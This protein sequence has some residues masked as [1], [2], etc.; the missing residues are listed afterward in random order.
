MSCRNGLLAVARDAVDLDVGGHDRARVRFLDRGVERREEGLADHALRVV[1]RADVHAGLGLAVHGEVLQRRDDVAGVD[2]PVR[3]GRALQPAHGGDAHARHQVRVLAVG[4]L[5]AAPARIAHDVDDGR[6]RVLRAARARLLRDGG[7]DLLDQRGIEAGRQ[8]D[9]L[10]VAGRAHA[11]HAVQPLFVVQQRDAEAR[12]LDDVLLQG[13]RQLRFLARVQVLLAVLVL[14]RARDLTQAVG[15]QRLRLVVREGGAQ[16]IVDQHAALREPVGG[17][18]RDLLFQRH[19]REQIGDALVRRQLR[20]EVLRLRE[21]G[22]AGGGG[23]GGTGR[24]TDGDQQGQG[25]RSFHAGERMP[26]RAP[27][28]NQP[29]PDDLRALTCPA[30]G[31]RRSDCSRGRR[32]SCRRHPGAQIR[33]PRPRCWSSSRS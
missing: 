26:N 32:S 31:S 3:L 9:R 19:A 16:L 12:V 17:E 27:A 28:V 10:R 24:Q 5:G 2:L 15:E 1:A 6:Q 11:L 21:R 25:V 4:L 7:H 29:R 8:R 30:T 33:R 13:V 14:R 20:V 18:L 23:G 22:V